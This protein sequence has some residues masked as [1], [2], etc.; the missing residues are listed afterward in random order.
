MKKFKFNSLTMRIWATFTLLILVIICCI[1]ISYI[2]VSV[3]LNQ[4]A[5]MNDLKVAHNILLE[6]QNKQE[7]YNLNNLRNLRGS[8]HYIIKIKAD[9]TIKIK[10]IK[11][12]VPPRTRIN[13]KTKE[14]IQW[15]SGFIDN[16]ELTTDPFIKSYKKTNYIIII[17]HIKTNTKTNTKSYLISYIPN[18]QDNTLLYTV[19]VTGILFIGVGFVASKMV[20]K[21]ISKP[22]KELEDY[23]IS[24]A[25]KDWNASIQIKSQDE[26]SRLANAMITM[27]KELKRA[28]E[29]EKMFLQSI[30]HDLK[31]PIMIIMSHAQ[32]I[33]D[34][35]YIDSIEKTAEIIKDEA[36]SMES[37]IK[38]ILY[39]NTLDYV[40]EKSNEISDIHLD[41]LLLKIINRFEIINSNIEWDLDMDALSMRGSESK[42]QV[43]IEN[44]LDNALRYA[45]EKI[46]I[47]LKAEGSSIILE[48][49]NDGPYIN[50]KSINKIFDYLYKDKTG[51]FGLGLTISKKIINFYHGNVYAV[52][53]NNG[54]SFILQLPK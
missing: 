25:K 52:N 14:M 46:S 1:S 12:K 41:E 54:V 22:L 37:K 18:N 51:N 10:K 50:E 23:T 53:K 45:K 4:K 17:S 15:V 38:Q 3:Y 33:I 26:I 40:L 20:A 5:K 9:N 32:S 24:I 36:I 7:A 28:D 39:L 31:T 34:G 8:N 44:I 19:F 49:H 29:E 21:H 47:K 35:I 30:S 43:A 16:T 42:I 2:F 6:S 27:Q 11:D 13:K 48:I